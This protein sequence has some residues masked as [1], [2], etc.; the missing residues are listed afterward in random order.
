MIVLSIVAMRLVVYYFLPILYLILASSLRSSALIGIILTDVDGI[1]VEL[2]RIC[3]LS[4]ILHY[5]VHFRWE[6]LV[7]FILIYLISF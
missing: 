6:P 1:A 4:T 3:S 7:D 2:A 5:Q